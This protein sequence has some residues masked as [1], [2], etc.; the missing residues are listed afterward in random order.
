MNDESHASTQQP[1]SGFLYDAI[2]RQLEALIREG[3]LEPGLVLLEKP[4]AEA[5]RTSRAPVQRALAELEAKGLLH[6][7]DGRGYLVGRAN[8]VAPTAAVRKPLKDLFSK[9]AD[10]MDEGITVR[11][12]WELI[13]VEVEQAVASSLVFGC[14]R[15]IE[16]ELAERYDVSRTV[17]RDV[18]GRLQQ[19]GLVHKSGSS[20]WLAG[21][22]T[23]QDIR[24][25]YDIRAALEPLAL[26]SVAKLV[27]REELL[28]LRSACEALQGNEATDPSSI[29]SLEE[30]FHRRLLARADNG[31]LVE[32]LD[33]VQRPL[34]HAESFMRSLGM[35]LDVQV[36]TEHRMV[37]DLLLV[38]ALDAAC[39]ALVAHLQSEA[40]RSIMHLKTAAVVPEPQL[41]PYLT[42][43]QK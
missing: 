15:I 24:Q 18:L 31:H 1:P 22:L 17:A 13:Y 3:R 23:A 32:A 34:M 11:S 20:H 8:G 12:S 7:F 26:R 35:P 27:S 39:A 2:S 6:R 30:E 19:S 5:F 4:L 14:Y 33:R 38:D 29:D 41:A 28:A 42:R 40:R 37:L 10:D 16:A 36:A 25:L 43:W 21:P 9:M